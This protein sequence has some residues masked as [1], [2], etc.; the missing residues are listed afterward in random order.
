MKLW[1]RARQTS[2]GCCLAITL[3]ALA[4]AIA[5]V[6]LVA[7]AIHAYDAIGYDV[8]LVS[9]QSPSMWECDGKIGSDPEGLRV[10]GARLFISYLGADSAESPHRLSLIHFGGVTRPIAPLTDLSDA[11]ARSHLWQLA[12]QIEPIPWT[13]P[14]AAMQT[15]L[16]TLEDQGRP[17]SRHV[18]VLLTDGEPAWP[19]DSERDPDSYRQ[20]LDQLVAR[21][22]ERGITMHIILLQQPESTCTQRVNIEWIDQWRAWAES[23]QDGGLYVADQA[24][25]LLAIY[26]EIVRR[27]AGAPPG[28]AIVQEAEISEGQPLLA[29]VR[30]EQDL[31]SMTLAVW[32]EEPTASVQVVGPDGEPVT[33]ESDGV[34]V[35]GMPGTGREEIWRISRPARGIWWVVVSGQGKVTVWQDPI[36]APTPTPTLTFTPSPTATWTPTSTPTPTLTPTAT[37]SPTATPAPPASPPQR[38][39]RPW[40]LLA[41]IIIAGGGAGGGALLYRRSR[42][43]RLSGQIVAVDGPAGQTPLLPWDLGQARRRQVRLGKGSKH[44]EWQLPGWDGAAEIRAPDR[45]QVTI[46]PLEGELKVNRKP[47]LAETPL[48]DGD[49]IECGPYRLRYENL[50]QI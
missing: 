26:H 10:D 35:T 22:R 21:I 2:C 16:E 18:M 47:V 39:A 42:T 36:P 33:E 28:S 38:G 27:L 32:K 15:A 29:P 49:E 20:A 4:I 17:D 8:I 11:A 25:D 12:G 31:L 43:P 41:G 37:A 7:R 46:K 13:D 34:I 24:Q 48:K 23:T 1:R 40:G 45:Y 30:V 50:M 44:A 6:L 9:D 14:L 5:L 3:S 19:E